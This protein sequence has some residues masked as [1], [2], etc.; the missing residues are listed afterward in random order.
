LLLLLAADPAAH[1]HPLPITGVVIHSGPQSTSIT[2]TVHLPL[3]AGADPATTIPPRLQI[4]LDGTPFHPTHIQIQRDPQNDTL[5]WSASED[6]PASSIAVDAPVFP[7]HP[8]DTTAVL[9]YSPN[10]TGQE[11][12]TGRMLLTPAH[13]SA[14][15]GEGLP[16]IIHRFVIMGILHILSGP[17]HILFLLGLI[18]A[19]GSLRQLLGLVTAFTLAHSLTLSLT[20]LGIATLSPRIVEPVIAFSI[21]VVGLENLLR[22]GADYRLRVSLAFGFGFFHGFGFA[23]ALTEAGLPHQAIGWSLAAFN[24]GVELGQGCIL[25]AI[26]PILHFIAKRSLTARRLTTRYLSIAIAIAGA[27]WFIARI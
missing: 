8:E 21:V 23:G 4:R 13:P 27:I 22:H 24:L 10:N 9:I 25:L 12:L 5:T 19:G 17:D 14:V 11:S 18:L 15:S 20:A 3:L 2:V 26:L 16:A 1:A 7:D 6:R